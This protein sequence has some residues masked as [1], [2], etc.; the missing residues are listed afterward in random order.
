MK[1]LIVLLSVF[2]LVACNQSTEPD[3]PST[4]QK[5]EK[6]EVNQSVVQAKAVVN[7]AGLWRGVLQSPGGELPFGIQMAKTSDGY[8]AK[9]ING[10]EQ[11]DTS[12]VL[13]EGN[14]VEIQFSW[15]D[16]RI[17]ATYH[18]A[19]NTLSGEWSK[20]A[21]GMISRLPFSATKG[22][23]YRFKHDENNQESMNVTGIWQASFVDEDGTSVAVGEF[24]QSGQKVNGTFLTPTGDYRFLSGHAIGGKLKLSAFDGA[25]AFLFDAT[26][27][28]G[29]LSGGFWSRDTYHANWSAVL[30][31]QAYEVLPDSWDMVK[32][33]TADN[34]V[35]FA[36]EDLNGDL[37]QLTDDRFK[38]K[39]VLINLFGTWCP[40]CNDEAPVLV[41]FYEKYHADG[42]E[43]VGLAFE[44]TEDVERDKKQ[45]AEFKK[46]Y[47]IQYPLLRAG[48]ND[49]KEAAKVLGFLDKVVA[50]PTS[51][52]LDRNHQVVNVHSG[53]AGPGT[54]D[55]FLQLVEELE[56]QI[57]E[58]VYP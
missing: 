31:E 35:S 9:I 27:S 10:N 12:A 30:N 42:L 53:F 2:I 49:K 55:H 54:G 3:Q 56:N 38:D 4:T 33:T 36:F 21:A 51:I 26:L 6:P 25:H 47:G 46:R 34:T 48:I 20:T 40:N 23:P 24:K 32:V 50:Y 52:F 11:A 7:L 44:F 41:D 17:K 14:Q 18:A 5:A 28:D 13:V 39:P 37:V 22:Y 19:D 58:I 16:A 8:Q 29:E 43:I 45:I 1:K 57:Q 15:Y